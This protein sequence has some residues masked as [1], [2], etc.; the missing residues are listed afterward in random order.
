MQPHTSYLLAKLCKP[1]EG[2]G[3]TQ[4]SWA[5]LLNAMAAVERISADV[6]VRGY[7]G[8]CT[9]AGYAQSSHGLTAQELSDA[10]TEHLPAI[11]ISVYY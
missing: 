7:K 3:K 8:G 1:D 4:D 10:G 2:R 6:E 5:A 11:T 9:G